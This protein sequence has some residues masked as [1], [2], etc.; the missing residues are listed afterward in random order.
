MYVCCLWQERR[1]NIARATLKFMNM[2]WHHFLSCEGGYNDEGMG[3]ELL[4]VHAD[5][6]RLKGA[7]TQMKQFGLTLWP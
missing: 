2:S 7:F 1:T 3:Y 5:W 4:K 6:G